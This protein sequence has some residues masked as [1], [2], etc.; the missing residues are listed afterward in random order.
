[1]YNRGF[2]RPLQN[3]DLSSPRTPT[4][5][6][7]PWDWAKVVTA[8]HLVVTKLFCRKCFD[9]IFFVTKYFDVTKCFCHKMFLSQ[10]VFVTKCFDVTKCFCHKMF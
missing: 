4:V 3:V 8:N 1:M 10:N 2:Q 6:A 5:Q 9:V 7:W